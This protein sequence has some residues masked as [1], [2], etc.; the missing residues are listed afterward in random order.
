MEFQH[1]EYEVLETEG[2]VV[3]MVTRSGDINQRSK[4]RCF[5]RQASAD[6]EVDY[7]ERPDTDAS[8]IEFLPGMKIFCCCCCCCCRVRTGLKST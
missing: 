8:A 5:T 2:Q 7:V 6:V 1:A 3:V 4:V